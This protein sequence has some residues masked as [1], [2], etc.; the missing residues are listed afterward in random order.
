[1]EG[2]SES[3][4]NH[5]GKYSRGKEAVFLQGHALGNDAGQ[6]LQPSG[7][8]APQPALHFPQ[9][10]SPA[11]RLRGSRAELTEGTNGIIP[12][13]FWLPVLSATVPKPVPTLAVPRTLLQS[14]A[15]QE[16]PAQRLLVCTEE[17]PPSSTSSNSR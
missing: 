3:L 17:R 9:L 15:S 8:Q 13:P 12:A 10:P 4:E 2:V 1:M 14:C 7:P 6:G 5:L 16:T 11:R